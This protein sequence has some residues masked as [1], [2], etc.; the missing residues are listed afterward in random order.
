MIG[1]SG[2]EEWYLD[3]L[4][5]RRPEFKSRTRHSRGDS[6]AW[7]EQQSAKLQAGGSNPPRRAGIVGWP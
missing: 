2:L 5:R 6:S 7:R 3:G 4:I 1:R